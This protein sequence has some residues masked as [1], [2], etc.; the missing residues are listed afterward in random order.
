M[1]YQAVSRSYLLW[2]YIKICTVYTYFNITQQKKILQSL[3]QGKFYA[4]F[5]KTNSA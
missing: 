5:S 3:S 2:R 1:R 4:V